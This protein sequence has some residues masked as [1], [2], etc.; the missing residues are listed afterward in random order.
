MNCGYQ[1]LSLVSFSDKFGVISLYQNYCSSL[2]LYFFYS[3]DLDFRCPIYG[4]SFIVQKG[5]LKMDD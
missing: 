1:G 4:F 5:H 2:E 3:Q